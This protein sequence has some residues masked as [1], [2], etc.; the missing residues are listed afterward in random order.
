MYNMYYPLVA[1]KPLVLKRMRGGMISERDDVM[2][3]VYALGDEFERVL[4]ILLNIQQG[5]GQQG[6]TEDGIWQEVVRF[7]K[8]AIKLLKKIKNQTLKDQIMNDMTGLRNIFEDTF[9]IDV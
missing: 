3:G 5:L 2:D 8:R 9:P 7:E 4:N 1:K 6:M